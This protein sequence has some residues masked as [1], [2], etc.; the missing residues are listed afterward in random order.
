MELG[1]EPLSQPAG[2]PNGLLGMGTEIGRGKDR[3]DVDHAEGSCGSGCLS[4]L[5]D[6]A[7]EP[8]AQIPCDRPGTARGHHAAIAFDH[9]NHFGGGAGQETFVGRI[10]V[11]AGPSFVQ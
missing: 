2:E 8:L 11:I 9:R 10:Y 4:F 6:Q 7:L 1:P 3:S 5:A